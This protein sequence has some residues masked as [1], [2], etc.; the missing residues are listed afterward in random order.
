LALLARSGDRGCT[1]ERLAGLLWPEA[2]E[3]RARHSLS[4]ALHTIR[5]GLG[6]GAVVQVGDR[7]RL[8]RAS[9]SVDTD[10]FEAAL[11]LRELERVVGLYTGPF[12]DGF[13]ITGSQPFD[14]WMEGERQHL[15]D[16]Y[17]GV[18]DR[19]GA[20]ATAAG[21]LAAAAGWWRQRLDH[22]PFCS[23]AAE[24]LMDALAAAGDRAA[25]IRTMEAHLHRLRGELGVEP[26]ASLQEAVRRL[27]AAGS[28]RQ[29]AKR[30][31]DAGSKGAGATDAGRIVP[32][33]APDPVL[34][35]DPAALRQSLPVRVARGSHRARRALAAMGTVAVV[36]GT[37]SLG[38]LVVDH[39]GLNPDLIA[40]PRFGLV[41]PAIEPYW[42][43]GFAGLVAIKL[44]ASGAL[45]AQVVTG[46]LRGGRGRL[47]QVAGRQLGAGL[48]VM[49]TLAAEGPDSVALE[50]Q[51]HDAE[52]D[53]VIGRFALLAHRD[54]LD[55]LANRFVQQVL[56]L[57]DSIRAPASQ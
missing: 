54:R 44:D 16:C 6:D 8:S 9:V 13:S 25:A 17:A 18:L 38:P 3:H 46:E 11:R 14:E 31:L 30:P 20:A 42:A 26:S 24:A 28:A 22:D 43:E 10:Q 12:L 52:R 23:H 4:E 40:V 53:R 21:D 27:R 51:L 41:G 37:V 1:R 56:A 5:R 2:D 49:G 50:A 45:G 39:R 34:I 19:L 7:L 15:A 35:N 29:P 47:A 33:Q 48:V 55:G 57:I 32:A 36:A